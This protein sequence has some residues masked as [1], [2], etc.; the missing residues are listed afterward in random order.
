MAQENKPEAAPPEIMPW[1]ENWLL[2]T[3]QAVADVGQA[4]TKVTEGV[5]AGKMPWE[6]D[7]KEKPRPEV[8]YSPSKD[9]ATV[10]SDRL[11]YLN[12][13]TG[14]ESNNVADAKNPRS[15]ATGIAQFTDSTWRDEVKASGKNYTLEDRK[16]PAKAKEILT[17]FTN[18]NAER[19]KADLGREP[20]NTDL[21]MYHLLGRNGGGEFLN[22]PKNK[23]ATDFVTK[24]AAKSNPEIFYGDDGKPRTV[25]QVVG[26]FKTKFDGRV[27]E[28][29]KNASTGIEEDNLDVKLTSLQPRVDKLVDE[30][31]KLP[32]F[33]TLT[34][35][36][37]KGDKMPPIVARLLEDG[38]RAAFNYSPYLKEG[39][40]EI[41]VNPSMVSKAKFDPGAPGTM[42]HEVAHA[43][44]RQ[45][46]STAGDIESKPKRDWTDSEA[47]FYQAYQKLHTGDGKDR[48]K[49]LARSLDAKWFNDSSKY[50]T[51]AN[52]LR[53]WAM[54]N[55]NRA[56]DDSR[57]GSHVDTT[58]ASE[59]MIL[60]DLA[61][62]IKKDK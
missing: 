42:V 3:N 47:Q 32:D 16:D 14:V 21:Y 50:R 61:S 30:T 49:D 33:Q 46:R 7:W 28:R 12:R 56:I 40:G 39:T 55:S 26:M 34:G 9:S 36:L 5:K 10:V 52:E 57:G 15:S 2:K 4:V 19:A 29:A 24:S 23:P 53:G 38:T 22:A 43:V 17:D 48:S 25:G 45:I 51:S 1:Q 18:R 54:G 37:K 60:V 44:D 27:I 11:N 20:T 13:L 59:F 8:S 35:F 31:S 6:L 41:S 62:K 58:L